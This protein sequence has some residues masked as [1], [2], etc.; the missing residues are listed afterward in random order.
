MK[1]L[2]ISIFVLILTFFYLK[3][4]KYSVT[5]IEVEINAEFKQPDRVQLFYSFDSLP[6][7]VEKNSINERIQGKPGIQKITFNIPVPKND[8]LTGLRLDIS[9]NK[10]QKSI[11]LESLVIKSNGFTEYFKH[12]FNNHFKANKFLH[13]DNSAIKTKVLNEKY[14]PYFVFNDYEYL[15]KFTN[16]Y[17]AFTLFE[18]FLISILSASLILLLLHLIK[19]K[20]SNILIFLFFI[21]ISLPIILS[22]INFEMTDNKIENR[23]L[24]KKPKFE[25]S[26]EY[27]K[28]FEAYYND[29]F[30]YRNKLTNLS[31]SLRINFFKS[32]PY[33][34]KVKF[35][36][37]RFLF[38]NTK[39]T[40]KSYT[41]NNLLTNDSLNI[42]IDS[43]LER[44]TSLK[45]KNIDYFFGFFPNKHNIYPEFLPFS[46]KGFK[47][48]S[49]SLADQLKIGF[50]NKG[51]NLFD[52]TKELQKNKSEH[53]LYQKLDSH[54]N[55]YG[56]FISYHTFFKQNKQLGV[57]PYNIEDFTITYNTRN[58]GD[59]TRLI[60]VDSINGYIE[61][62]P[63]LNL[64]KL[65]NKPYKR[66][67]AKGYPAR[68]I[69]T[70]NHKCGNKKRV[71]FFGDSYSGYLVQFISLHFYEVVYVRSTYNEDLVNKLNPN[72]VMEFS[73]ERFLHK[74]L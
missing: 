26:K 67:D 70:V 53:L 41:K 15:K 60:G 33:P 32:S 51:F 12:N 62:R 43:F 9:S 21:I 59:L 61:N 39:E 42:I 48:E 1:N 31:S 2:I 27:F 37:N 74:N 50:K 28:E 71:I 72:I 36:K 35:G 22:L 34:N 65:K 25:F 52:P 14:D 24:T 3:S 56:A 29:Y 8:V 64:K 44:K 18:N 40:I 45:S 10:N 7:Y 13:F 69:R 58:W 49:L 68:T 4:V 19:N 57:I 17:N 38:L 47:K 11:K 6:R 73:V 54:W 55:N 23:S 66:L 63:F 16:E 20:V 5:K 46:M 30:P